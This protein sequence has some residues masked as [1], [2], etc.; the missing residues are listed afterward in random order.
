MALQPNKSSLMALGA[1]L[2]GLAFC[3]PAHAGTTLI[4]CDFNGGNAVATVDRGIVLPNYPGNNVQY[5]SIGYYVSKSGLY[6]VQVALRSGTFDGPLVGSATA[7]AFFPSAGEQILNFDFGDAPVSPGDTVTV[8]QTQLLGPAQLYFDLG[9]GS[10]CEGAYETNGT[11]PPLDTEGSATVG[12]AVS[13]DNLSGA[14]IPS[15]TQVCI[16]N[17]PGDR[18]FSAQASFSTSQNGGLSGDAGAVPLKSLG[19]TTGGALWFF[20]QNNPE[21]MIK[22]LNGCTVN[23]HYWVFFDAGTNVGFTLTVTDTS[24]GQSKVYQNADLHPASPVQDTLAFPC[25]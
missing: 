14:C 8:T 20:S 11:R 25:P 15:D 23:N 13:E 7:I 21:V 3:L 19:L 4:N 2:C 12:I 24:T 18:R 10:P 17:Q 9:T 5:V 1:T 6:E 22:V 16:D